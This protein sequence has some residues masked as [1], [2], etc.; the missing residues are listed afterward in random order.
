MLYIVAT[1]IGNLKDITVRALEILRKVDFVVA[2]DTRRTGLL[3]KHYNLP[4]K[5]FISFYKHN[6]NKRIDS[7]I[8]KLKQGAEVALIS[9]AGTPC[10]SD[11]GDR[12]VKRCLEENVKVTSLPGPSA[13]TNALVLSGFS[14]SSYLFL[15]FLPKKKN[16]RVKKLREAGL[17]KATLVIFESP[18]RLLKLLLELKESIGDK[19]CA[20]IREMTKMY[21]EVRRDTITNLIG[22]FKNKKVRGEITVIVDNRAD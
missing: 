14:T 17:L 8:D 22:H 13:I 3:L 4:K 1:P 19:N 9:N 11:P 10:I 18:Y 2:E 21:E 16:A 15:E 20:I 12:L 5:R 6:E 7:I